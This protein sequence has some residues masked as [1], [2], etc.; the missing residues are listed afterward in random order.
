[1][2]F[3]FKISGGGGDGTHPINLKVISNITISI[4]IQ[5]KYILQPDATLRGF[6]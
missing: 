5:P 6:A 2:T 1:M 3:K 4:K